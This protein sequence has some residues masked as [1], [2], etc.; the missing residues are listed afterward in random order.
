MK[1][2]KTEGGKCT[3]GGNVYIPA[4]AQT[5]APN[6]YFPRSTSEGNSFTLKGRIEDKIEVTPG[7]L[8]YEANVEASKPT[9]PAY[10]MG[11]RAID[12][13][14]FKQREHDKL[15]APNQYDAKVEALTKKAAT[16]KG[17]NKEIK[18][19]VKLAFLASAL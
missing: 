2:T 9:A 14:V 11:I 15:P 18:G 5:P 7:P 10:T 6:D 3:F 8:D 1:A 17:R 4:P 12:A 19:M 16:L 13:N